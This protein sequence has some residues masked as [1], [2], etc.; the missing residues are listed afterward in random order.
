MNLQGYCDARQYSVPRHSTP[1]HS[2]QKWPQR[3]PYYNDAEFP[4]SPPES[5]YVQVGNDGSQLMEKITK[6]METQEAL[7]GM[8]VDLTNRVTTMEHNRTTEPHAS[9]SVDES[10]KRITRSLT[11]C[12]YSFFFQV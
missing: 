3:Y 1:R 4:M 7:K 10:K 5:N 8:L 2:Q 12:S 11:V 9:T 6:L